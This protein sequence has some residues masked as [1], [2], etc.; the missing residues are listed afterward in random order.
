M[1]YIADIAGSGWTRANPC[2]GGLP[3]RT[4]TMRLTTP[5]VGRVAPS[6]RSAL[7]PRGSGGVL[8]S[9]GSPTLAVGGTGFFFGASDGIATTL[10]LGYLLYGGAFRGAAIASLKS[11]CEWTGAP[12][13]EAPVH[14]AIRFWC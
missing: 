8:S 7:T 1:A 12:E 2:C 4:V 14:F 10:I 3:M 9:W 6:T 11:D 13:S 5:V